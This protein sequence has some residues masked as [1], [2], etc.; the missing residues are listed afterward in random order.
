MKLLANKAD[1]RISA[2][3]STRRRW[4]RPC[5][6]LRT[7]RKCDP[8]QWEPHRSFYR[9]SFLSNLA[10]TSIETPIKLNLHRRVKRIGWGSMI[11]CHS[12]SYF[13]KHQVCIN[14]SSESSVTVVYSVMTGSIEH[15]F[16]R[17]QMTNYLRVDPKLVQQIELGMGCKLTGWYEKSHRQ[18]NNLNPNQNLLPQLDNWR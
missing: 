9:C 10:G 13:G 14:Q 7:F 3:L 18:K 5:A 4:A 12:E 16:E 15:P 8:R 2:G 17:S 6:R 11:A 1:W